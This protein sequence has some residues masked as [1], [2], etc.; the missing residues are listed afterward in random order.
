MYPSSIVPPYPD[1]PVRSYS[2]P[3]PGYVLLRYE[4]REPECCECR[5]LSFG[6]WVI[7]FLLLICGLWP[8]VWIP[9]ACPSCYERYQVPVYG[10]P[11]QH[12]QQHQH[13]PFPQYGPASHYRSD[14]PVAEW[15]NRCEPD[16]H[17]SQQPDSHGYESEPVIGIPVP[18]PS[19]PPHPEADNS[20]PAKV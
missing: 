13:H 3:P 2:M 4:V 17:L 6:G 15:A 16:S 8:F 1:L 9:F 10:P 11:P 12:Q 19:A 18:G 20:R 5:N 7:V 14:I